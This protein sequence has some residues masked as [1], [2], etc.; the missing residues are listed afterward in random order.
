[1]IRENEHFVFLLFLNQELISSHILANVLNWR[2][3]KMQNYQLERTEEYNYVLH[4]RIFE[5][6]LVFS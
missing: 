1:M 5:Y 2:T 3:K 6:Q 4:I